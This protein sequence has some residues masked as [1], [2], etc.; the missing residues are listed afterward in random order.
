M[1]KSWEVIYFHRAMFFFLIVAIAR[2]PEG[3]AEGI[4]RAIDIAIFAQLVL[5]IPT[6]IGITNIKHPYSTVP[7]VCLS[8]TFTII[9][10]GFWDDITCRLLWE[11]W[12]ISSWLNQTQKLVG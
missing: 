1:I 3:F 12:L 6:P 11:S 7:N 10:H 5:E 8:P 9:H 4:T 2:L